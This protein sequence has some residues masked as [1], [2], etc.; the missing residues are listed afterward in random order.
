MNIY[1]LLAMG[2]S[3]VNFSSFILGAFWFFERKGEIAKGLNYLAF[4]VIGSMLLMLT[5]LILGQPDPG[6]TYGIGMGLLALSTALFWRCVQINYQ[7]KLSPAYS[8]DHP[9][10]LVCKGPYRLIR[11]PYYTAYMLSHLGAAVA[12]GQ[13]WTVFP[14]VVVMGV[15]Y[16]A[17]R[18]EE[19]KFA[20]SPLSK[21]YE[22][23][24]Q[25]AGRFLPRLKF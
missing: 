11:H 16:H 8:E 4:L 12:S 17:S 14:A 25:Q 24:K 13:W 10:H 19:A 1:S 23:Y 9:Q 20:R 7:S 15:Y 18:F 21:A 22:Q 2:L 5:A 3:L 6:L